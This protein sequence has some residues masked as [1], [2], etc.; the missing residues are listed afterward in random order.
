MPYGR[1]ARSVR[2]FEFG[3]LPPTEG[4]RAAIDVMFGRVRLWNSLVELEKCHQERVEALLAPYLPPKSE[5]DEAKAAWK[6]ARKAVWKRDDVLEAAR[7]MD[8]ET[9]GEARRLCRESGLYWCNYE[10]VL[11]AWQLARKKPGELRFHA[12]RNEPG[13]VSV[14]YQTGLPVADAFGDDTRMQVEPVA[15]EAWTSPVRSERRKLARTV[16]RLR[17]ASDNRKPVWLVLP[18][19]MHRPLPADG[20]IRE[21]SVLR[22]RVGFSWRWKAVLIVETPERTP[23]P[24]GSGRASIDLGWRRRPHGLRVCAWRDDSGRSGDLVLPPGWLAEMA[25]TENLRSIRDDHLNATRAALLAWLIETPSAPEWIGQERARFKSWRSQS[26]MMRLVRLWRERRFPGDDIGLAMLEEWRRRDVHLYS[27]EA[28]LRDQLIRQRREIYR[29]FAADLARRYREVVLE[30]F[31]LRPV[32]MLAKH[33][34]EMHAAARHQRVWAAP[35]VLRLA[36]VNACEREGLLVSKVPCAY[37]TVICGECGS[38]ERFDKAREMLHKC[39]GCGITFDQDDN[40]A[41]NLLDGDFSQR[42]GALVQKRGLR[43]NTADGGP[44]GLEPSGK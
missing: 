35:S 25:K 2:A 33:A 36:V 1:K 4:E 5:G 6:A 30:D 15:P 26:S 43:G 28:N 22:E 42:V 41:A 10:A 34:K 24:T 9:M 31:D 32:V 44:A 17:V 8:K 40:A 11:V 14:R 13:K 21:C 38:L 23:Q 3:C 18:M 37:T 12:A 19:V 29:L 7:L 27:Y 39:E 16:L 20:L